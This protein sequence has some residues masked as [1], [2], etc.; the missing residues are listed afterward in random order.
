MPCRNRAGVPTTQVRYD[1]MIHGFFSMTELLD[2]AKRA[3][4]DAAEKV[5]KALA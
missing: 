2:A 3:V 5:R 4:A 1:G